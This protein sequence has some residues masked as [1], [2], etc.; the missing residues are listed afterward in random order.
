LRVFGDLL[1]HGHQNRGVTI[2]LQVTKRQ[3]P[4]SEPADRA[5][6]QSRRSEPMSP[7]GSG[8]ISGLAE[9]PHLPRR[10]I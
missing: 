7:K 5:G 10:H 4:E 9:E 6:T 1:F 2:I 3:A 8:I